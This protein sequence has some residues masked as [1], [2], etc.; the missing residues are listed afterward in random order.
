MRRSAF[1]VVTAGSAVV[2]AVAHAQSLTKITVG[3]PGSDDFIAA[4]YADASGAFRRTGLEVEIQRLNSGS[5]VAVAVAGGAI[6]IG[7][8]SLVSLM[9]ARAKNLPFVVVAPAGI[10]VADAPT[11]GLVVANTSPLK[12]GKD[13]N[14][15]TFAVSALNDLTNLGMM[16]WVDR[17]GGDSKSLH[18]VEMPPPAM[19]EAV[20][21]GRID[22]GAIVGPPFSLAIESKKVRLLCYPMSAI[23]PRFINGGYFAK[24]DY[25]AKNRELIAS[26]R[27]VIDEAGLY[28]NQ[29]RDEMVP[30]ISKFSGIEPKVILSYPQQLVATSM[31]IKMIQ[32]LAD[33]AAAYK[34][35]P[36]AFDVRT[37]IDPAA[38]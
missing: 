38:L 26:F 3:A 20:A 4:L 17:N 8:S 1:L 34:V 16:A 9:A 22:G 32:P 31:D 29:H 18:F 24:A 10:Y 19:A 7:K 12:T 30:I 11:A 6:D 15:K 14:G 5:A 23:S 35:I 25:V 21:A 36:G 37:M 33:V 27:K 13:C 2:P 28:A